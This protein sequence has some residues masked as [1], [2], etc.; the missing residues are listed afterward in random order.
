MPNFSVV[1][2][3][4]QGDVMS[5]EVTAALYDGQTPF[6]PP[7]GALG[8]VRFLKPDGTSGFYDTM[9][10]DETVAV[11]WEGNEATIKLAEQILTVPG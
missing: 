1:V 11:T 9:E 3:A 6:V 10:D 2:Y 5:R 7:V 8:T 4:V